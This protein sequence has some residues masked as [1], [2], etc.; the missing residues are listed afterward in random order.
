MLPTL[1]LAGRMSA[2]TALFTVTG[3]ADPA[4]QAAAVQKKHFESLTSNIASLSLDVPGWESIPVPLTDDYQKVLKSSK[5]SHIYLRTFRR[6][7]GGRIVA[8][9]IASGPSSV[10]M[11]HGRPESAHINP[12]SPVHPKEIQFGDRV[13]S[14][15]TCVIQ[16]QRF[17]KRTTHYW[18][19]A[20]GRDG[21]WTAKCPE[22][23]PNSPPLSAI[24]HK[25]S[26]SI[27]PVQNEKQV[28][29]DAD[30]LR[31]LDELLTKLTPVLFD[32]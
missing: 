11:L 20:Y 23:P 15:S 1:R 8:V 16:P 25:L 30:T 18:L 3:C 6:I 2:I 31:L 24:V 13:A 26:V 12:I 4:E 27:T 22:V 29:L 19:W 32:R 7:Q 28:E 5:V 21:N 10:V 9:G 17:D 14:F